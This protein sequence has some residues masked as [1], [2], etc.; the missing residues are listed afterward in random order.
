[1]FRKPVPCHILQHFLY[2]TVAAAAAAVRKPAVA[3]PDVKQPKTAKLLSEI[4]QKSAFFTFGFPVVRQ[5]LSL[6]LG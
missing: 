1:M 3:G 6:F 5:T 4:T 2:W